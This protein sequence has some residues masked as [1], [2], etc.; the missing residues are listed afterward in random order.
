[1]LQDIRFAVRTLVKS[2]AFTI[3]AVLC[4]T[5]GIGVNATVFSC[6]RA[7]LLRP[8]PYRN[9]DEIVAIA[10]ATPK[11]DWHM[12]SVSYP[13]F[14][15]WQAAHRTLADIGI[16]NGTSFNLATE[17]AAEYIP[18]GNVSWTMFHTLGV[19]PV[20][21][22]DFHEDEDRV[23]SPQVIIL[24]DRLWHDRFGGRADVVNQ[25][26]MIDGVP[27]TV[28]GVMP[29]GF[30]FPGTALAWTT[31]QLDATKSRGNHSWNVIGRLKPGITMASAVTDLRGVASQLESQYPASNGGWS[32][33]MQTLRE[34]QTGTLRPVLLIMM[35]AV[36]FVL[37][38]ACA[39][40][41]NLLLA[42]AAARTKE[43]A[44]RV[45]LGANRWRIVRQLLTES[46]LLALV[47]AAFGVAFAYAG[48]QWV[49]ANVVGMPFW[50]QFTIDTQVLLFTAAVAVATGLLFGMAPAFQAANPNLND[51]LRDSGARGSSAGRGR[52]RLRSALVVGEISLSLVLLVGAVLLIRSF[53]GMQRV[54]PGFD[55]SHLLTMR[56]TLNGP[57]Y[58]STFKR[59]SFWD[60]AL[61]D[62][63]SQPDVVAAAIANNIPLSGNNNNTFMN[64]EG[65]PVTVDN[66]PLLEIRWVSPRYLEAMRIPLLRGRM[67]TAQE[68]ADSTARR[69]GGGDQ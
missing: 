8:F 58:D 44:V 57:K 32:V 23:G 53:V 33:E 47:G 67:F 31:V 37:L 68:G 42:R 65:K 63:N 10:E 17:D 13:N 54:N 62:L 50:M 11:R 26:I 24:S 29:P 20:L 48:L 66:Q 25:S 19:A 36:A 69:R 27:H 9:P 16:Y 64:I 60:R 28:I 2:P 30:A 39:N 7:L 6:V 34:Y 49:K 55:A 1:M 5:L 46:I 52:Q 12:N 15:S 59:F 38:I 3:A 14:R 41:A 56:V 21:G 18:G 40:V 22:R 45:A 51:T 35:A 61:T 43:T 4:L